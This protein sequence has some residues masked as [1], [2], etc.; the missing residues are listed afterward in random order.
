MTLM[1]TTTTMP[2]L[3]MYQYMCNR[4]QNTIRSIFI[5][6]FYGRRRRNEKY[7]SHL[8]VTVFVPRFTLQMFKLSPASAQR[9]TGPRRAHAAHCFGFRQRDS[10]R[11]T[12]GCL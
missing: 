11:A 9:D 5:L 7:L 6:Q 3:F 2:I 1:Y 12:R 8:V 4:M 10:F